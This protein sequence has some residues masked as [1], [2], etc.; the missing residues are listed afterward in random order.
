[1]ERTGRDTFRKEFNK[2]KKQKSGDGAKSIVIFKWPYYKILLFLSETVARRKL[3][4]NVSPQK[5]NNNC[6]SETESNSEA[7]NNESRQTI[8]ESSQQISDTDIQQ[9]PASHTKSTST[10]NPPSNTTLQQQRTKYAKDRL[11]YAKKFETN[12]VD[13]KFLEIEKAKLEI[14]SQ[15]KNREDSDSEHQF[16]MSLLPFLKAVPR[17]RQMMVRNKLQQVFVDED[18][19]SKRN[20]SGVSY[21]CNET[22]STPF[23]SPGSYTNTDSSRASIYSNQFISTPLTSPSSLLNIESSEVSQF[24]SKRREDVSDEQSLSLTIRNYISNFGE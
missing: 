15:R 17:N 14:M 9:P 19:L 3:H 7:A 8:Q 21:R 24:S 10:F 6:D 13:D 2:S 1:M 23:L 4:G 11:K 12:S 5:E 20:T 22:I 18:E 16:L